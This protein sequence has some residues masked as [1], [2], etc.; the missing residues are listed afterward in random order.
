L[1]VIKGVDHSFIGADAE[2]T[3]RA[4]LQ[5]LTATFEFIDA[6]AR[7]ERSASSSH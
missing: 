2:A 5:A 3:R 6:T 4:S 7:P 1:L